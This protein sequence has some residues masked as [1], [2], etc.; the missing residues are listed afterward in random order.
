MLNIQTRYFVINRV[1]II[2]GFSNQ[3]FVKN[4]FLKGRPLIMHIHPFTF[5]SSI[6]L[7]HVFFIFSILSPLLIK[8]SSFFPY[9]F[10]YI[11]LSYLIKLVHDSRE[12]YLLF[13]DFGYHKDLSN[14][15]GMI[16]MMCEVIGR[17]IS[18]ISILKGA[19][20]PQ[21]PTMRRV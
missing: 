14:M 16:S 6:N 2:C 20:E 19:R 10:S 18:M 5:S 7:S 11:F 21:R 9:F 13:F 12:I 1:R 4:N 8:L 17:L 15:Y 3:I